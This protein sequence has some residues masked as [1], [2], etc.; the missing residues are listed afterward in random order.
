MNQIS[1]SIIDYDIFKDDFSVLVRQHLEM[2]YYLF[3]IYVFF[4]GVGGNEV[5]YG[6]HAYSDF[7][8]FIDSDFEKF[9]LVGVHL[10]QLL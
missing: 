8:D 2:A 9:F 3:E 4:M 7:R 6:I 1:F 10:N 5:D